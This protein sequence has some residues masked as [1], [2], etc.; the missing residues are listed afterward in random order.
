[1]GLPMINVIQAMRVEKFLQAAER[2]GIE[3]GLAF[4][5]LQIN[6][7]YLV[8]VLFFAAA[9]LLHIRYSS[10]PDKVTEP[11]SS[12]MFFLFALFYLAF[13]HIIKLVFISGQPFQLNQALYWVV[14]IALFLIWYLHR[15][16]K[17][18][19][20]M[21]TGRES[22]SRWLLLIGLVLTVLVICTFIS[23][24]IHEGIPGYHERF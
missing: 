6:I 20:F 2:L 12:L 16:E 23:I 13:S 22:G 15:N 9:L 4:A 10:R 7:A 3:D 1:L 17:N 5:K 19:P 8:T 14:V 11:Y 18:S 21:V 24:N